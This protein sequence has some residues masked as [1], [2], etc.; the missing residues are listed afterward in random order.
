[1]SDS[2]SKLPGQPTSPPPRDE[3]MP[4]WDVPPP[5]ALPVTLPAETNG[6]DIPL[7][8]PV[9]PPAATI[10]APLPAEPPPLPQPPPLPPPAE[11][12][13]PPPPI[14][15]PPPAPAE[16]FRCPA[17]QSDNPLSAD[18]CSDC[19]YYFSPADRA[20]FAPADR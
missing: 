10:P 6:G 2:S 1:M 19:G 20:A 3:V 17:C 11:A 8:I 12:I 5:M 9:E 16:T 15:E 14:M 7:A 18:Y 4:T 13:E